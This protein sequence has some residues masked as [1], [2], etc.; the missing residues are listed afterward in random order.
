MSDRTRSRDRFDTHT[1]W[2][3]ISMF[4]VET[5]T[6][7]FDH[8]MYAGRSRG[9][10]VRTLGDAARTKYDVLRSWSWI[11]WLETIIHSDVGRISGRT[12]ER[13]N[14]I[15]YHG[16]LCL[17]RSCF[18]WRPNKDWVSSSSHSSSPPHVRPPF[19]QSVFCPQRQRFVCAM[20]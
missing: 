20:P 13:G 7:D 12:A 15:P 4:F 18:F 11:P 17:S 6:R 1:Y 8:K 2:D 5:R 16:C 9:P 10:L 14:L 3:M 19:P